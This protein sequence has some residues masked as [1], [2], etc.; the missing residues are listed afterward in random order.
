MGH[1]LFFSFLLSLV[2]DFSKLE[3]WRDDDKT[4]ESA[5]RKRAREEG[6]NEAQQGPDPTSSGGVNKAIDLASSGWV[7]GGFFN[8]A[9]LVES[10]VTINPTPCEEVSGR[11]LRALV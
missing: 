5:Q 4:I 10:T 7:G 11:Q 6:P 1:I 8:P 3:E 9:H 2:D